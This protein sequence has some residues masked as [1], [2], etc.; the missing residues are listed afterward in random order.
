LRNRN[1]YKLLYFNARWRGESARLIFE[2]AGVPYEDV[3]ITKEEWPK[4]KPSIYNIIQI[5]SSCHIRMVPVSLITIIAVVYYFQQR[6]FLEW[7]F[8]TLPLNTPLN[9]QW[10]V[11]STLIVELTSR[12]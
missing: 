9:F 3:R 1:D 4:L 7:S 10:I 5:I 11:Y 12:S 2:Y 8:N 6:V